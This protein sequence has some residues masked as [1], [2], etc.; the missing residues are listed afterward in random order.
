MFSHNGIHEPLFSSNPLHPC[1]IPSPLPQSLS[2][3][4]RQVKADYLSQAL[5]R[6]SHTAGKWPVRKPLLSSGM[7][8]AAIDSVASGHGLGAWKATHTLWHPPQHPTAHP[9]IGLCNQ[10]MPGPLMTPAHVPIRF[11]RDAC[12]RRHPVSLW[13][14]TAEWTQWDDLSFPVTASVTPG[15]VAV[16]I[17]SHNHT[18]PVLFPQCPLFPIS[19][20]LW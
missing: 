19:R 5:P 7:P 16:F 15:L 1:Q 8:Q 13:L 17:P 9:Q 12:Q 11:Q 3:S 10:C 14:P 2:L 18:C 4:L 6:G 20:F